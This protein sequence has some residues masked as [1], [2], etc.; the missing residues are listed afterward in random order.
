MLAI[1]LFWLGVIFQTVLVGVEIF[2]PD[3][4]TSDKETKPVYL[5]LPFFLIGAAAVRHYIVS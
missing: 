3:S 1:F 5:Y 2:A 4:T